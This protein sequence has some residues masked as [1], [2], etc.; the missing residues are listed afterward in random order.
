[1]KKSKLFIVGL[2]GLLLALG[3][4]IAGCTDECGGHCE[5]TGGTDDNI[6]NYGALS[7]K[8]YDCSAYQAWQTMQI[9]PGSVSV[10]C[11]CKD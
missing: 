2:I 3:L 6:C 11:D 8:C 4:V 5:Y 9:P 7:I 10:G 1:M